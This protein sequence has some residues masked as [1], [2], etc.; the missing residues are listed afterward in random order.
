M[1][2]VR[3]RVLAMRIDTAG[4]VRGSCM[5]CGL[6]LVW[7]CQGFTAAVAGCEVARRG[8]GAVRC[9]GGGGSG[10]GTVVRVAALRSAF[11]CVLHFVAMAQRG[12]YECGTWP[13]AL[14]GWVDAEVGPP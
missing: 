1:R 2:Q 9:G 8:S 5:A 11:W 14:I 6:T 10:S 3:R 12:Q 13:E 4:W 7:E